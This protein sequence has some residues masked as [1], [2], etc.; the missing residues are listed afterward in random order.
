MLFFFIDILR[1]FYKDINVTCKYKKFYFFISNLFVFY[2]N[3][4]ISLTSTSSFTLSKN[5]EN[6]PSYLLTDLREENIH[7]FTIA[8]ILSVN[9]LYFPFI[10]LSEL[11]L[12][13][14][15]CKFLLLMRIEFYHMIFSINGHYHML[16]L[17]PVSMVDCIDGFSNIEPPC[18]SQDKANLIIMYCYF[19]IC[20]DFIY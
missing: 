16:F 2:L 18:H 9:L 5:R 10:I 6:R 7:Y 19:Y 3:F 8:L 12:I 20:L 4:S 15:D 17:F 14:D 11:P 1:V 13:P